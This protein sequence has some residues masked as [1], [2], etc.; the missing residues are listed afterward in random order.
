MFLNYFKP[1]QI[2]YRKYGWEV[3]VK[4]DILNWIMC[5]KRKDVSNNE[6]F[7]IKRK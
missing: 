6:N 3:I 1:Y 7:E 5:L 4:M 2:I